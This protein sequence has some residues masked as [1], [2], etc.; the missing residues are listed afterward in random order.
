MTN[1]TICE[2]TKNIPIFAEA[3]VAVAGGGL[4]GVLAAVAAARCGASVILVERF[5]V[6]GGP[7]VMGLPI[8]GYC[9]DNDDQIVFG[10]P[11]EF[12][13]RLIAKDGAVKDFVKCAMHNPFMLVMPE[14]VKQV[15]L[16]MLLE[17]KVHVLLDTMVVD[18]A[19]E[20]GAIDAIIIEGKSGRQAIAA[21]QFI[22]ATGDADLVA[23]AG[24]PY[25]IAPPEQLQAST[26]GFILTD[27]DKT[28]IQKCLKDDPDAYDL[29]PM[30][31]REQIVNAEY[32][33]MAGLTKLTR[34]AAQEEE[35]KGLYGM[36]NFVTLPRD[37]MVYVNSVHVSGKS[38]CET[39][40]VSELEIEGAQQIDMVFRFL[41][42]Y[43]AG[44]EHARIVSSGPFLGIRE[45]RIIA[46]MD[47]L[48]IDSIN[49][50]LIPDSTIALGGYPYD[51]HQKDCADN[52]V[53]FSK[54]PAYGITFGCMIPRGSRNLLVAGKAISATREA[55]CSSRVMAQCMAEG[56]AA[57][58]AAAI[59]A[60]ENI[61]IQ[62]LDV[63]K[64]RQKLR[65]DGAKLER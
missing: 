31:P 25:T 35:F 46:G 8:Q 7:A 42:K 51:F 15:C 16:E 6:L 27:V 34:K 26:M 5:S 23:R 14:T 45:S 39:V 47:Q 32:Y 11:E 53:Q 29:Y 49:K 18:V 65:A 19:G 62:E 56:Q 12:R 20:N 33:I 37:D 21:R 10:L 1:K 22:D 17:A 43:V 28:A 13:Q 36:V 64:L 52:K 63:Q 30:L 24:L 41:Q 55:M 59:C 57:G 54:V 50:G 58:T 9:R 61:G 2:R 4:S 60:A 38:T 48:T 40:G 44:F 3:D